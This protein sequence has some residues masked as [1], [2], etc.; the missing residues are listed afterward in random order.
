[1]DKA[2]T[3]KIRTIK[4]FCQRV[5][6]IFKLMENIGGYVCTKEMYDNLIKITNANNVDIT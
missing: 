3:W 4:E 2:K 6:Q 1:M 5:M